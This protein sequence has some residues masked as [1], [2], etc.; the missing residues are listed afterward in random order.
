VTLA[1]AVFPQWAASNPA[2]KIGDALE[3]RL[4]NWADVYRRRPVKGQARSYEGNFRCNRFSAELDAPAVARYR[5]IHDAQRIEEATQLLPL[6]HNLLLRFHY[7]NR[8]W[9]GK[10]L[11]E[12]ARQAQVTRG[13]FGGFDDS[14][15][16]AKALLTQWLATPEHFRKNK[17][18]ERVREELRA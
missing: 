15:S 5:D 12:A 1:V 18:A 16:M 3:A 8:W 14:L 10:C 11:A 9:R 7:I 17:V 13:G 4:E 2:E 6:Y